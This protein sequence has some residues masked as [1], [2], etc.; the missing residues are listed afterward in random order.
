MNAS[1]EFAVAILNKAW[2]TLMRM[3]L[4][5]QAMAVATRHSDALASHAVGASEYNRKNSNDYAYGTLID[6]DG[7]DLRFGSSL[8]CE[9]KLTEFGL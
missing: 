4:L 2:L 7:E 9:N 8:L 6:R 3:L 5:Q 1:A